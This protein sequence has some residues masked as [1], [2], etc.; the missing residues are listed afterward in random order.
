MLTTARCYACATR[1]GRSAIGELFRL[2][3]SERGSRAGR[4]EET[5]ARLHEWHL[6]PRS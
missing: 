3:S 4:R 5:V 6:S 2:L 1:V